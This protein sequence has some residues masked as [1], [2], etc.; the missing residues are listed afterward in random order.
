MYDSRSTEVWYQQQQRK[1]REQHPVEWNI[2]R[3]ALF[4]SGLVEERR[5]M[6]PR[7]KQ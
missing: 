1:Q 5:L 7:K 3:K 2:Y 6:R 4:D